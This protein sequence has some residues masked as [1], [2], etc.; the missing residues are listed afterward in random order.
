VRGKVHRGTA[1]REDEVTLIKASRVKAS[2]ACGSSFEDG[3]VII[4]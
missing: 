2:M 1:V 4:D 3:P